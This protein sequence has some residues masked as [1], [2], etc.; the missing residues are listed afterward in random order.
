MRTDSNLEKWREVGQQLRHQYAPD[1]YL[2][3]QSYLKSHFLEPVVPFFQEFFGTKAFNILIL[4]K[5]WV[6]DDEFQLLTDQLTKLIRDNFNKWPMY[7]VHIYIDYTLSEL[8]LAHYDNTGYVAKLDGMEVKII[9]MCDQ[10]A[11]CGFVYKGRIT[12][13]SGQPLFYLSI[14]DFYALQES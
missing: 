9:A 10:M 3:H 6:W 8:A 11:D 4:T 7:F 1:R 2:M 5:P 12:K 14:P 13:D